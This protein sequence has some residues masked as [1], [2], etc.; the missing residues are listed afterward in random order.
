MER[1]RDL[2]SGG[3]AGH[4]HKCSDRTVHGKQWPSVGRR[5]GAVHGLLCH[6]G[7]SRL[8]DGCV[9]TQGTQLSKTV[10]VFDTRSSWGDGRNIAAYPPAGAEEWR[11]PVR[12][13]CVPSRPTAVRPLFRS[14]P[15]HY[16]SDDIVTMTQPCSNLATELRF[17]QLAQRNGNPTIQ[18][19][20]HTR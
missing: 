6:H 2:D 16:N 17:A 3:P 10:R 5:A 20:C 7:S 18:W 4:R 19:E 15:V 9:G 1:P 14:N 12:E 8:R 13:S 11:R